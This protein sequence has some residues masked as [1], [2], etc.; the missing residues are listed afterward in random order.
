MKD[1]LT[2]NVKSILHKLGYEVLNP[3]YYSNIYS[4]MDWYSGNVD[5]FHKYIQYNGFKFIDKKMMSLKMPKHVCEDWSSLLYNDDTYIT[6]TES[7][8]KK[9]DDILEK[10]RFEFMFSDMLEY[11]YALGT[12]ATVVYK[13][14]NGD[15]KI[16]YIIAPMIFPL[17]VD[18]KEITE[19][20]FASY[21]GKKLYL[22]IHTKYRD[23]YKI[24]NIYYDLSGNEAKE[25]ESDS[26]E[27]VTYSY[28]KMF[29]IYRP[30]FANNIDLQT[31]LGISVFANAL[32]ENK[33]IDTI[34]DSY[35]NEFKLGKKKLFL[36]VGALQYKVITTIDNETVNVPIFDEN[37]TEFFALPGEEDENKIQ[38][39]NPQLRVTE[40]IDGLQSNMNLFSDHCGLGSDRFQFKDGKV[41]TNTTQVISTNSKLYKNLVKQEKMLRY[42][43]IE[44]VK[45]VLYCSTGSRYEKDVTI[46]FDDSIIEDKESTRQQAILE[47]NNNLIDDVQY[48]QDVYKMSEDQAIEF[49]DKIKN[50]SPQ[51][52]LDDEGPDGA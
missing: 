36:P 20:A 3:E 9:L 18:N 35:M 6:V 43:M 31:P 21:V 47:F 22:N 13:K 11:T 27:K 15:V 37:Q 29:Q 34:Y 25:I 42:S 10:N 8:Q 26:V 28:E 49:R 17:K 23:R 32:D 51:E 50:R 30:N 52:E 16:N 19:C 33:T 7:M 2:N 12:G 46:D 4:W 48:Y 14:K 24:E 40:H 1:V 39:V 41:Y 5:D 45:A 44:L 38:E